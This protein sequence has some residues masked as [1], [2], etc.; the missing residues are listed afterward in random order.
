MATS[1]TPAVPNV[2][3]ACECARKCFRRPM[4][5]A[6]AAVRRSRTGPVPVL[7]WLFTYKFTIYAPFRH[8]ATT[9]WR[10]NCYS[11]MPPRPLSTLAHTC[12][13]QAAILLRSSACRWLMPPLND[14]KSGLESLPH[15]SSLT[16]LTPN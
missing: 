14:H 5:F 1:Q 13:L 16:S 10:H 9:R 2:Y 8:A 11:A 15:L 3:R 12:P 7:W 6:A 4:P